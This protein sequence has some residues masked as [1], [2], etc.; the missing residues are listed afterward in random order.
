M[1]LR[2]VAA[3]GTT[4]RAELARATGLTRAT[5]SSLVGELIDDGLVIETGQ[6]KSLG[7]KPPTLIAFNR[8]ARQV[9]VA[10]LSTSPFRGTIVDLSC[11][12]VGPMLEADQT[13]DHQRDLEGLLARLVEEADGPL[14]GIGLASPGVISGDGDVVEAANLGWHGHPLARLTAAATGLGVTVVNDAHASAV[15]AHHQLASGESD[16]LL[17]RIGEGVGAGI[18]LGGRLHLG[19]HRAAG[20]IGHSVIEPGGADC[21]CGN[22]G[23]L[24]TVASSAAVPSPD[25][26]RRDRE[27]RVAPGGAATAVRLARRRRRPRR[28]G[29]RPSP[30]RS[31]R[32][33]PPW[34]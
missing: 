12:P 8:A 33:S 23:C 10:D 22:R 17:V 7:G 1:V 9:I 11:E 5:I 19:S 15:A 25:H 4:T 34:T 32:W 29:A 30:P 21:R 3:G 2:L 26:R 16:L 24:E 6:G 18:I 31:P 14:V 13:G 27:R 20:E 28:S